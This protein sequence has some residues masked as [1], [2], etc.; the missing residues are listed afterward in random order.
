MN[1]GSYYND[2]H[3]TY[4]AIRIGFASLA[5]KEMEQVAEILAKICT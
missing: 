4:N 2:R 3:A 1:D 5:T